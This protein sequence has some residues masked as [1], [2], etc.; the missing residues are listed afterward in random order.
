M[1]RVFQHLL[2][3]KFALTVKSENMSDMFYWAKVKFGLKPT[4]RVHVV[5]LR[6]RSAN[7][8]AYAIAEK[9]L[10]FEPLLRDRVGPH[11]LCPR[12]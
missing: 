5:R 3:S 6:G 9:Q 7:E 4:L 2:S 12:H 1:T 10:Y 11:I 8:A